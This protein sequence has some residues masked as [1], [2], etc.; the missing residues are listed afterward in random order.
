LGGFPGESKRWGG[1]KMNS[2]DGGGTVELGFRTWGLRKKKWGPR[3]DQLNDGGRTHL[4][5]MT[6]PAFV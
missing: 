6:L 3:L 5:S 1:D 2:S 4:Y